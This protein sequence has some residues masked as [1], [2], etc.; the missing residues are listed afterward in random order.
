MQP[1][2]AITS[3]TPF[4][5][6]VYD[7]TSRR[8]MLIDSRD[9]GRFADRTLSRLVTWRAGPSRRPDRESP[10]VGGGVDLFA[11]ISTTS[12]L[13]RSS[14]SVAV[15]APLVEQCSKRQDHPN[16]AQPADAGGPGLAFGAAPP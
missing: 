15:V 8:M 1:N 5:S 3:A 13:E 9:R 2:R 14:T 12:Q 6:T 7:K 11:Q 16:Y 10:I 4:D